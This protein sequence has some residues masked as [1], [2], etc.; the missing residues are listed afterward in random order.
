[1]SRIGSTLKSYVFWTYD[2]GSVPYDV[3][4]TLILIFI[5]VSPHFI[6]FHDQPASDWHAGA[7]A[8]QPDGAGGL[9]F[10]VDAAALPA[11]DSIESRMLT[12]IEPITGKVSLKRYEREQDAHGKTIAYKAW[13]TRN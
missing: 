12:A 7:L 5:F 1:M 8:V 2:R 10:E 6:D 4:V 3:M 11:G 13:V 9:V